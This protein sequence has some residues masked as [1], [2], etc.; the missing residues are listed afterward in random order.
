M[1]RQRA[2]VS[3]PADHASGRCMCPHQA[4]A[5]FSRRWPSQW[6]P[7]TPTMCAAWPARPLPLARSHLLTLFFPAEGLAQNSEVEGDCEFSTCWPQ[8]PLQHPLITAS[9]AM[10]Y[11]V[12]KLRPFSWGGVAVLK[13]RHYN[14][15]YSWAVHPGTW[16]THNPVKICKSS[17]S[18]LLHSPALR[19]R[20]AHPVRG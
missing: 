2:P 6:S 19:P 16:I 5:H 10:Y 4:R 11:S 15:R 20:L 18:A 13:W 17:K 8:R 3:L 1:R 14:T 12:S 7:M 9:G